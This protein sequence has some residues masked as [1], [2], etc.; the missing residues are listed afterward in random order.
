MRK[1][2]A[3]RGEGDRRGVLDGVLGDAGG[4][5]AGPYGRVQSSMQSV[6]ACVD[7]QTLRS[8]SVGRGPHGPAQTNR[9]RK[10]GAGLRLAYP[11]GAHVS[12]HRRPSKSVASVSNTQLEVTACT[13]PWATASSSSQLLLSFSRL[14]SDFESSATR[15]DNALQ[16]ID[17]R[18][19]TRC[20]SQTCASYA[21]TRPFC[22]ACRAPAPPAL[23]HGTRLGRRV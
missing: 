8:S 1:G 18:R 17:C 7:K 22:A 2:G 23:D 4:R 13:A 20:Q 15:S 16:F 11:C 6:R 21:P 12:S 10:W 5:D 9:R 14:H 3:R 19:R